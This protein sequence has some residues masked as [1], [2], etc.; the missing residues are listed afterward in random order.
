MV[1]CGEEKQLTQSL[2]NHYRIVSDSH[3][4]HP[5]TIQKTRDI[6]EVLKKHK[7]ELH[8][9]ACAGRGNGEVK[10]WKNTAY[11][12]EYLIGTKRIFEIDMAALEKSN[13]SILRHLAHCMIPLQS[14]SG[15]STTR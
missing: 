15:A 9:W 11:L 2:P 1:P 3:T 5:K 12:C 14:V 6:N 10:R 13:T 7:L 8:W 4:R